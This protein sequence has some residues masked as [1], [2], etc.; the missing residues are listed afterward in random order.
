M[1]P[2]S[3]RSIILM[4]ILVAM[5]AYFSATET[6]FSTFNRIRIKNAAENGS[7]RAALV[8]KMSEDYDRLLSTILVGNNL[9]NILLTTVATMF[10]ADRILNEDWAAAASTAVTTV[11][12]LVFGEISPKSLAKKNADR[13]VMTTAPILRAI[14]AVLAPINCIFSLWKKLLD[15][16]F[17]TKDED[18]VTEEELL[19]IVD[20]AA[21]D[22]SI[23]EQES[24]MIHRVIEFSDREA[25]DILIP[26]VDVAAVP[27][28]ATHKELGQLFI[29]SGYSRLPVYEDTIDHVVGVVYHKDYYREMA[30]K[31]TPAAIMKE[32]VFVPPT[33]KI[34]S[35]LTQLQTAQSHIAIVT[36][37]YGGTLGIVT[38]EDILEELVGEIWD[39]HDDVVRNILPQADGAAVVL[40]STELIDLME[41]FD[42]E[43]ECDATTVS[44]WVMETLGRIPAVG[45]AFTADGLSVEVTKVETTR[46]EEIRV[47]PATPEEEA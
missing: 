41:Y 33:V 16:I 27:M 28:D 12:V 32:A 29:E 20:E 40:C 23:N 38:M 44:G 18:T 13:F 45:D 5:S 39:E 1:D 30:N 25:V 31:P 8:L 9:V 26:R 14:T 46:P 21:E 7:K 4:L 24:E 3:I 15:L 43:T 36:D 34:Q 2:D 17:K 37:E 10:F 22:G 42:T 11:V 19:T 35:L 47:W 6:A